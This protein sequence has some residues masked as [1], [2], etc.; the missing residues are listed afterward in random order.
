[1]NL[2]KTALPRPSEKPKNSKN[3][4]LK[5]FLVIAWQAFRVFVRVGVCSGWFDDSWLT[6][7]WQWIE[8][9]VQ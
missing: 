9:H 4:S 5:D 1:M 3:L 7:V 2:V 6:S 8:D